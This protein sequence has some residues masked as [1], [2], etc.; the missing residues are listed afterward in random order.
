MD[1]QH[2]GASHPDVPGPQGQALQET[3]QALRQDPLAT[4]LTLQRQYGDVV[5]L[6]TSPHLV[7]LLSHPDAV[8]HVLRDQAHNYRKG[9]LFQAIAAL[10]G[11]GLLTSEGGLWR[12][13]RRLLQPMFHPRQLTSFAPILQEEIHAVVQGWQHAAQTGEPVQVGAWLQRFTFR[14]LARVVLGLP[15]EVLGHLGRQLQGLGAQLIPYLSLSWLFTSAQA[16]AISPPATVSLAIAAY[17]ELAR[18]IIHRRRQTL[19]DSQATDLLAG[20]LRAQADHGA[21]SEQHIGDEIITFI[22]AGTETTAQALTWMLY[23]L[24]VHPAVRQRVQAEIASVVGARPPRLTDLPGLSY[25]RMVLE[26]TLRLY[27]PAALIPRQVNVADTV[28]GY[29]IPPDSVILLSPYVTHRH[30]AFWNTPEAFQP[31]RFRVL[32]GR[33]RH[34]CAFFPFGAGPRHCI[35]QSLALMEM[36]L[37]LSTLLQAY[38]FRLAS[39]EPVLPELATTLRPRGGL[40][41][42]L[43]SRAQ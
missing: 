21:P 25:G 15:A 4:M 17:Q 39:A 26:E 35:G 40:W 10:Q 14:V 22:G 2:Q 18:Q 34:P 32:Q 20:L 8:Q 3:L 23:V 31:E 9:V 5:C 41:L 6:R 7:Y 16:P 29:A 11:Q 33:A 19:Q 1:R 12:Q 38:T 43:Q 27:P 42:T 28:S 13:Q 24:A 30:A 36:H 37:A